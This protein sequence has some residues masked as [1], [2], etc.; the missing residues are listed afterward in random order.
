MD[1]HSVKQ[2]LQ[3]PTPLEAFWRLGRNTRTGAAGKDDC[4]SR[5]KV[6]PGNSQYMSC[7][8]QYK[9]SMTGFRWNCRSCLG[10]VHQVQGLVH[11]VQGLVHQVGG[12]STRYKQSAGGAAI[13][14]NYPCPVSDGDAEHARA[15]PP[16]AGGLIHQVGGLSTRYR[17]SAGRGCDQYKLPTSCFRWR[18]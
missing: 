10:L 8:D 11:Q 4:S 7:G 15:C 12:L 1:F 18:C 16:S 17:Q 3:L 13:D 9:L 5:L 2:L 14:T 6:S